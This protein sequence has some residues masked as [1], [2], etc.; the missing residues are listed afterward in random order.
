MADDSKA[1][2]KKVLVVFAH[3]NY[4]NSKHSKHLLE[5]LQAAKAANVTIRNLN[6]LYGNDE[7]IDLTVERAL[8]EAS[9]RIVLQFPTNWSGVPWLMKKYLDELLAMGWFYGSGGYKCEGKSLSYCTTTWG[10]S[11]M[12]RAGGFYGFT[13]DESFRHIQNIANFGKMKFITPFV[14]SGCWNGL[15]DADL[16]EAATKYVNWVKK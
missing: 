15:S 16:Q 9:D 13:I 11:E 6:D 1:A 8:W 7:P 12:W 4:K 3:G 5:S 14:V 10:T 2:A